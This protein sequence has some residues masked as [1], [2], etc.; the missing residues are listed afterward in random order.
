MVSNCQMLLLLLLLL[1]NP[2]SVQAWQGIRDHLPY[3]WWGCELSQ[4]VICQVSGNPSSHLSLEDGPDGPE[5]QQSFYGRHL[6]PVPSYKAS[7][8]AKAQPA[9]GG[10]EG[11]SSTR[12]D[13][14]AMID[15][16]THTHELAYSMI[17][18]SQ[19]CKRVT[20]LCRESVSDPPGLLLP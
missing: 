16:Q 8:R 19:L 13:L 4:V 18:Q 11:T 10:S 6:G 15:R 7:V 1:L 2:V 14:D 20:G 12:K 9:N 17:K 3:G 5:L